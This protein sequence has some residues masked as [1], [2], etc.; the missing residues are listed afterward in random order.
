MEYSIANVGCVPQSSSRSSC[1][2]PTSSQMYHENTKNTIAI[3]AHTKIF[4]PH[5]P[6][7]YDTFTNTCHESRT[8]WLSN[9]ISLLISATLL[10]AAFRLLYQLSLEKWV[11]LCTFP[12]NCQ[13]GQQGFF[14]RWVL[15]WFSWFG[16]MWNC[17]N[18]WFALYDKSP[19]V[20]VF[21]K[22]FPLSITL[23]EDGKI[24]FDFINILG[25]PHSV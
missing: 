20:H 11:W 19:I 24:L 23:T 2:P 12:M 1:F 9:I 15:V 14:S 3:I 7:K 18:L 10:S 21:F 22:I 8:C 16:E 4:P 25:N 13:Y 17:Q 6:S 5:N